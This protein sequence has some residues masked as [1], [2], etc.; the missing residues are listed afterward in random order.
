LGLNIKIDENSK[1]MKQLKEMSSLGLLEFIDNICKY[2]LNE[3]DFQQLNY[4]K[5]DKC[6][7]R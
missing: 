6:T 4:N 2:R 3:K 7:H 1:R 5:R